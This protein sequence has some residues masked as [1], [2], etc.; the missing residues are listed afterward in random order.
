MIAKLITTAQTRAE[1]ISKMRKSFRWLLKESK[2]QYRFHRQLMDDPRYIEGDYTT[3]FM[4]F[5]MNDQN[6]INLY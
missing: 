4:D 6:N 1:A 3:A 2:L 5:K